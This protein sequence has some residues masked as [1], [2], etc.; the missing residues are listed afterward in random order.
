[1]YCRFEV[2]LR[3]KHCG[4]GRLSIPHNEKRSPTNVVMLCSECGDV[5]ARIK[6]TGKAKWGALH[7][8]C[9]ACGGGMLGMVGNTYYSRSGWEVEW[10]LDAMKSEF[11]IAFERRESFFEDFPR[12]NA[13]TFPTGDL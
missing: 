3:G 11:L 2:E 6:L 9:V 13:A 5:W 10:P 4:E 7:R 12:L 8:R 1:M